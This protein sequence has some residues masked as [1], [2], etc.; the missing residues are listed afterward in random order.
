[1]SGFGFVPQQKSFPRIFLSYRLRQRTPVPELPA[2]H[3]TSFPWRLPSLDQTNFSVCENWLN[4]SQMWEVTPES[5]DEKELVFRD[6][7]MNKGWWVCEVKH[8]SPSWFWPKNPSFGGEAPA[9]LCD[10]HVLVPVTRAKEL[11]SHSCIP[12]IHLASARGKAASQTWKDEPGA[13]CHALK[14][15]TLWCDKGRSSAELSLREKEA[16]AFFSQIL[17]EREGL[18]K[19][20]VWRQRKSISS[21]RV[22]VEQKVPKQLFS[23][24]NK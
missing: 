15:K 9:A 5:L 1:M 21:D 11:A 14:E 17:T 13:L 22:W 18:E 7:L 6:A 16:L 23:S 8:H 3:P 24:Q 20:K 2:L 19:E 10:G 4:S 12:G